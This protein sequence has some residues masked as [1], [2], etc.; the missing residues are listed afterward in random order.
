M[1]KKSDRLDNAFLFALSTMGLLI[2]LIQIRQENLSGLI[3][4]TPF[5]FLGIALPF[6]VGYLRG[7]TIDFN[8][9][10]RAL[11]MTSYVLWFMGCMFWI[12]HASLMPQI[13]FI[14]AILFASLAG[15]ILY[16]SK[17]IDF[18]S[19]ETRIPE[20]VDYCLVVFLIVVT[21]ILEGSYLILKVGL[22]VFFTIWSLIRYKARQPRRKF[23]E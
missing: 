7:A 6:Y 15:I 3:E 10:A 4:A 2:S 22:I 21:M 20:K 9:K 8:L 12:L 19:V 5:L 16:R 18:I 13:F 23:F 11:W 1:G 17:V 14:L